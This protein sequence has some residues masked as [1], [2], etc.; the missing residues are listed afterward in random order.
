M[1]YN[2][3]EIGAIFKTHPLCSRVTSF[4]MNCPVKRRALIE[5]DM[6]EKRCA[7]VKRY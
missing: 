6:L 3:N 4:Y 7:V 2:K 1:F 5:K